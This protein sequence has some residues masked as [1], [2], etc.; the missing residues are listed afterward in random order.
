[1]TGL[2]PSYSV[3][4]NRDP[5]GLVVF[6]ISINFYSHGLFYLICHFRPKHW[7]QKWLKTYPTAIHSVKVKYFTLE[8]VMK[9]QKGSRDIDVIFL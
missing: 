1:M 2:M 5:K 8:Q 7:T 9:N 4:L 3:I 6:I